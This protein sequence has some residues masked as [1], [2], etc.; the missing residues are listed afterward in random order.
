MTALK[1]VQ[2]IIAG[3]LVIGLGTVGGCKKP[4]HN[5]IVVGKLDVQS[6]P[7]GDARLLAADDRGRAI[8]IPVA[9]DG[10]FRAPL[11]RGATWGLFVASEQQMLPVVLRQRNAELETTVGVET[12]GAVVDLGTLRYWPGAAPAPESITQ[13]T[14]VLS[15]DV[16]VNLQPP[17][18][19]LPASLGAA[20]V[21]CDAMDDSDS[22]SDS[23]SDGHHDDDDVMGVGGPAL[24][25]K[26][27][28]T[29]AV[30]VGSFDLPDKLLCAEFVDEGCHGHHDGDMK[31][32]HEKD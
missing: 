20:P 7:S 31:G 8:D 4:P 1:L 25:G 14:G 17:A 24:Q 15:A 3:G 16:K 9:A 32:D 6:F 29:H 22:D 26:L 28:A 12:G 13:A 23:D 5:S 30:A 21:A 27:D 18:K 2:T 10:S 19:S 11:G